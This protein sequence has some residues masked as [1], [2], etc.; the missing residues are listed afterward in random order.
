[1]SIITNTQYL[2]PTAV[3]S[4][5]EVTG[6]PWLNP[7][8]VLYVDGYFVESNVNQGT[9][10]DFIIGNFNT[11]LSQDAIIIGIELELIAKQGAVTVPATTLTIYA[12]DNTSGSNV[13]Y[14]YTAPVNLT[15]DLNTYI[16]GNENYLFDQTSWTPDQ[17]NNLKI[18]MVANGDVYVDSLLIKV[19]YY[20]P[21]SP[22]PPEP[23][24]NCETCNSPIQVPE[25]FLQVPFLVG[26]TKFY[27]KPGSFQY[28]N[29]QPVQP[30]DVGDCGGEIDLVF[31]EGKIKTASDNPFEE[32][33]TIDISNGGIWI[34]L[35]NGVIEVDIG[36]IDNR[37]LLPYTPYTHDAD[38]MSD[39]NANSKVIISNNG[40][41][42]SRFVRACQVGTI[43]SAPI[44]VLDESHL[45]DSGVEKFN[46]FG[47]SVEADKD[48]SDPSKVNISVVS[49]PTNRKP[50]IENNVIGSN[51]STPGTSLSF[52]LT[53]TSA[54]YLRIC[55]S[56]ENVSL[57]SVTYNGVAATLIGSK[58]NVPENLKVFIYG[59]INPTPGTHNISVT[60]GS[61]CFASV[62]GFGVIGVDTSNPTDGV[63]SG[64]IGAGTNPLDSAITTTQNTLVHDIVGTVGTG[65]SFSPIVP[66]TLFANTPTSERDA[67]L[68]YR[69]VLSPT[70]VADSY[71]IAP[72]KPWAIITSGIR[73]APNAIG[74]VNSVT[75]LNTDNTDPVNPVVKISVDTDTL[76]GQGTPGAPIKVASKPK[77]NVT[78]PTAQSYSPT[79]AGTATLDLNLG[80]QN[81]IIMPAGNI[82]IAL[83]N[84]T[85]NQ[86]FTISITQDSIGSRTVTWFTTIRWAGGVAPTLTTTANKRDR[87]TFIRTGS[88]TY[89][90]MV[91]GQNI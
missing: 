44:S 77:I 10:S 66:W 21:D 83:S 41:F 32:N 23:S 47:D 75:G 59:L 71:T 61:A 91:S 7:D 5:G 20:T 29:G 8:N 17:I 31:D 58:A 18:Q 60:F 81:D 76:S 34:V 90:G 13:F 68:S 85:N 51:A 70:T 22:T 86:I 79:V 53:I 56:S 36:S 37:G 12:V 52:P 33:V 38:L 35:E 67:A 30:G 43:F 84:A 55:I 2:L 39:H 54:N 45:I 1:M 6:N 80:N 63:S 27:L 65:T 28:V 50:V 74:G 78:D 3:I 46:F 42:Y 73:G 11:N 25:M 49:N 87:F 48:F 64:A 57:T 88:G 26:Q 9:A 72:N 24:D 89:D 14:P 69:N 82:T 19:F 4:N 62:G 16:L 40:R 15:L